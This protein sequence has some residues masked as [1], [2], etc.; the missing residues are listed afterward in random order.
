MR[1]RLH[2]EAWHR[3]S[4]CHSCSASACII[5]L[6]K[7]LDVDVNACDT[8]MQSKHHVRLYAGMAFM[9]QAEPHL[10]EQIKCNDAAPQPQ[11]LRAATTL[12][13]TCMIGIVLLQQ[14]T[15]RQLTHHSHPQSSAA[16]SA[17]NKRNTTCR[18]GSVSH[19][20]YNSRWWRAS[21][22]HAFE[23]ITMHF[24]LLWGQGVIA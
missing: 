15:R 14:H 20:C 4:R 10:H 23:C 11:P 24:L 1:R 12:L 2:A 16:W 18:Q 19:A 21:R 17:T 7:A 22:P 9:L 6:R 5:T 3:G 13:A 8:F